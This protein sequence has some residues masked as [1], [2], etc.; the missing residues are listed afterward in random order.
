MLQGITKA[1]LGVIVFLLPLFFLPGLGDNVELPKA[2]ILVVLTFA[3]AAI[4]ALSWIVGGG[5]RWRPIPGFWFV[6]GFFAVAVLSTIFS[7]HRF[8]S[9]QGTTGYVHH[10][11]PVMAALIV[12]MVLLTQALD[13][14]RDLEPFIGALFASFGVAGLLGLLQVSGLSPFWSAELTSPT[15]LVSGNSIATLAILMG[16]LLPFGIMQLRMLKG[17]VWKYLVAASL[18]V[19]ALMLLALDVLAGWITVIVGVIVTVAF[20][21]TRKFTKMELGLCTAALIIAFVGLLVSTSG[22]VRTS[23]SQDLRLDGSS[24]WAITASTLKQAPIIGTGPGTFYYDFVRYRPASLASTDVGAY[25]FVKASDEGLQLLSTVGILGSLALLGFIVYLLYALVTG[26]NPARSKRNDWPAVASLAGAWCGLT[27]ALFFVP[28]TIVSFSLFWIMAGLLALVLQKNKGYVAS[29]TSFARIGASIAFIVMLA[30]FAVVTVW[31]VRIM[32]ADR[33]LV[34]VNAAVSTVEDLGT[35]STM[36][37]RAIRLNPMAALP[38]VL[39]AQSDLVNA[40]ILAQKQTDTAGVRA[41]LAQTLADAETAVNRDTNNTA[42]LESIAELY[43]NYSNIT[44]SG[45]DLV[46][47]AYERA[48]AIEPNSTSLQLNMGEA[49]YLVASTLSSQENAD[50][51]TVTAYLAKART[52]LSTALRLYPGSIDARYGIVMVDELAGRKDEAFASL[53]QLV[54]DNPEYGSLWYALGMRYLDRKDT[55]KATTAFTSAINLQPSLTDAHWQLGLLAEAAKD[56]VTAKAQYEI[57]QQLDSTNTEVQGKLD[58]LP[59][60]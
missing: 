15:F 23:V 22:I 17:R 28:S 31:T 25:R 58:G 39:R 48:V 26:E 20:V 54:K 10:T 46:L 7:V 14:E 27:A 40:Q 36:I 47:S 2:A 59:K 24:S 8:S 60:T 19:A 30:V 11:L 21:S 55:D 33:E 9:L 5:I 53:Q 41:Y 18:V 34:R 16:M 43:K 56:Y 6:V 50:Q 3:A 42:I 32:L 51:T 12:L 4:W 1:L 45:D 38:Y 35:V 49:Y 52:A 37:D 57:V 13:R 29:K 44:G